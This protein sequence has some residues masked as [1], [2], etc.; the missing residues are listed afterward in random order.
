[1]I[2]GPGCIVEISGEPDMGHCVWVLFPAP[3]L[4]VETYVEEP[5]LGST[6]SGA[7]NAI[8]LRTADPEDLFVTLK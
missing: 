1:M 5:L 8:E 6:S 4:C 7:F 2:L 3:S